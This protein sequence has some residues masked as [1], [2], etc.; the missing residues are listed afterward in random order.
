MRHPLPA[1][2]VG[3]AKRRG[4]NY[5][6]KK[7]GPGA[8]SYLLDKPAASMIVYRKR[9]SNISVQ[10]KDIP[11]RTRGARPCGRSGLL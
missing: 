8:A 6:P 2:H 11:K 1:S 7:I 5:S 4:G 3:S 10:S 9:K